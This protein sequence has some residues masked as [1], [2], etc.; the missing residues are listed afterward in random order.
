MPLFVAEIRQN[1]NS[2]SF[3]GHRGTRKTVSTSEMEPENS[4]KD[5]KFKLHILES[6]V[7]RGSKYR[8]RMNLDGLG[9]DHVGVLAKEYA[10]S[11]PHE[12]F[13]LDQ[14]DMTMPAVTT[15]FCLQDRR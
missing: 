8:E 9:V 2:F 5:S 13:K 12:Y 7:R 6:S 1:S 14:G 15:G 3:E 11:N 10:G 4:L